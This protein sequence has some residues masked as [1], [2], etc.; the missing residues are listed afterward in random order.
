MEPELNPKIVAWLGDHFLPFEAD[1]RRML[2]RTCTGPSEVDDVIQETYCKILETG[3]VDHILEP[4][5]YVRQMA[6]NIVTDRMRRDAVV[7]ID[8]NVLLDE[9]EM[10]DVSA[11]PERVAM[12]RS[13][14]QWVLGLI[15]ALPDRCRKVFRARR[16]NEMSQ[17]ET[18]EALGINVGLV[19]YEST[20]AL[21]LI[22]QMIARAGLN[23]VAGPTTVKRKKRVVKNDSLY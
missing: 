9:L 11:S 21:D 13:E 8:A 19:E 22:S 7:S 18:A 15:A 14:L 5:A 6:K 4:R 23:D 20:R 17:K 1:L 16:F 3:R 2:Q 12:A 10:A